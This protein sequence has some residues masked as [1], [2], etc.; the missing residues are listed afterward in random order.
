MITSMLVGIYIIILLVLNLLSIITVVLWMLLELSLMLLHL[1]LSAT[2]VVPHVVQ[3]HLLLDVHIVFRRCSLLFCLHH[4][5]VAADWLVGVDGVGIAVDVAG[6][7]MIIHG[8]ASRMMA[9]LVALIH[10]ELALM[11]LALCVLI[12]ARVGILTW[13]T[14]KWCHNNILN[15]IVY[16]EVDRRLL[17]LGFLLR[18]ATCQALLAIGLVSKASLARGVR[19]VMRVDMRAV[20]VV[21]MGITLAVVALYLIVDAL[22]RLT[23]ILN[24]I[25]MAADADVAALVCRAFLSRLL[26]V[27]SIFSRAHSRVWSDN[28]PLN[29]K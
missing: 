27:C 7:V 10:Q 9:D 26:G 8:R 20:G 3:V 14:S 12:A 19:S 25:T 15:I 28:L 23:W 22:V 21:L 16:R 29:P 4:H 18:C 6:L 11:I 5:L 2:G 13:P 1:L 24:V 17:H